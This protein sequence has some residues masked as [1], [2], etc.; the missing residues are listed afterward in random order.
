MGGRKDGIRT[1]KSEEDNFS[2]ARTK[3]SSS[4][5]SSPK[6]E[7]VGPGGNRKFFGTQLWADKSADTAVAGASEQAQS[8]RS[9]ELVVQVQKTPIK[10]QRVDKND[11]KVKSKVGEGSF[12]LVLSATWISRD[13]PVVLKVLK[14]RDYF[15]ERLADSD[16]TYN[17]IVAA[18]RR[19]IRLMQDCGEHPNLVPI[20]GKGESD[21][22]LVMSAASMDLHKLCK[23]VGRD[24]SL[25]LVE[26]WTRDILSAVDHIHSRGIIHQDVKTSNILIFED[27]EAKICDFG[28]AVRMT[29]DL[30][31][32][33]E[34][35]TLWYRAPEL[36]MGCRTYTPKV[37]EWGVGCI[38][39]EML[40]GAV[41]FPG[42]TSKVCSCNRQSHINFNRDQLQRIFK[43][44]GSPAHNDVSSLG[45]F[46]H[47]KQW[48]LHA[49]SLEQQIQ[50][51][52]YHRVVM[53]VDEMGSEET[54][55]AVAM[56]SD[57]L[58]ALLALL[59]EQRVTSEQA[60]KLP[61][62][63]SRPKLARHTSSPPA[64][65]AS[66]IKIPSAEVSPLKS[67][68]RSPASRGPSSPSSNAARSP[69]ARNSDPSA[70][71]QAQRSASL[72]LWQSP[73]E[74]ARAPGR[75]PRAATS[76][77]GAV[78]VGSRAQRREVQERSSSELA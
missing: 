34:L 24:L 67:P 54:A 71:A 61:I 7:S 48:P 19:E 38:V 32:N 68:D 28:L 72:F 4:S 5:V 59:P 69:T 1:Q 64:T 62:F 75:L 44:V 16:V 35:C 37:D 10:L 31:V 39:L 70:L 25:Q 14:P 41:P 2:D 26:K 8:R 40:L 42:D 9:P 47:F 56:W 12:G 6:T 49:P 50:N 23:K 78:Q 21:T 55:S 53:C 46:E 33:R 20:L 73:S 74:A 52:C 60:L 66:P 29:D 76:G 11:L 22:M 13:R 36:L 45:C 57:V 17:D 43:T 15:E 27:G 65:A 58:R 3:S 30:K 63:G 51:A 77:T 18:F